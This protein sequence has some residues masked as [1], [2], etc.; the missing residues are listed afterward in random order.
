[1]GLGKAKSLKLICSVH[2]KNDFTPMGV[3]TH[4]TIHLDKPVEMWVNG[5]DPD[6]TVLQIGS[7]EKEK[8][9]HEGDDGKKFSK[10]IPITP[11]GSD[12]VK[13]VDDHGFPDGNEGRYRDEV[14]YVGPK[15]RQKD[16]DEL[17]KNMKR[18]EVFVA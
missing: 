15:Y 7:S 3:P 16:Y 10:D 8:A 5:D 17:E 4:D 13:V 1:M 6:L 12:N 2:H 9:A 18:G 14:G 11:M